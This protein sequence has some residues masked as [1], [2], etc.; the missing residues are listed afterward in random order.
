MKPPAHH[1]D[2][3]YRRIALLVLL[4]LCLSAQTTVW[5]GYRLFHQPTPSMPTGWYWGSPPEGAGPGDLVV[6]S[7]P[8]HPEILLLKRIAAAAGDLVCLR[9]DQI[10]ING[11]PV[12]SRHPPG[13]P[14]RP[15]DIRTP[16]RRLEPNELFVLG[17][18]P[19]SD[20]SRYF[21]PVPRTDLLYRVV[22]L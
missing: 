3:Q 7:H 15:A 5:A 22:A 13:H 2:P 20:D 18:H 11:R 6:L 10:Q 21:G 4:I 16:C 8:A 19:G 17:D 9:D 1:P 14:R 12:A